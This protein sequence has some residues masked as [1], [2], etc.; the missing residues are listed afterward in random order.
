MST[1]PSIF[2]GPALWTLLAGVAIGAGSMYSTFSGHGGSLA[3]AQ[4]EVPVR[5]ISLTNGESMAALKALDNGFATLAEYA[6]PAV[7][8][9]KSES[10]GTPGLNGM[11]SMPRGGEGSGVIFRPNG[12]IVTNDH[13]V[14]GFD[15]V[16]VVLKD[17]REFPG[18]VTRAEQSDIAVVKIDADNLPTLPFADSSKVRPGEFAMAIGAPFGLENTVTIGHVSALNRQNA[19]R[20]PMTGLD[21][22]Y[23]ELIQT[24]ASINMGNSG[25]PLINVDGQVIGINSSIVSPNGNGIGLGFAISSNQ[26]RLLAETLI[27]KGK[28]TRAFLGLVPMDLKDYQK[29]QMHVDSGALVQE[30]SSD[31]PAAMAGIKA[32]DVIVRI[33]T[34]PVSDQID[35]RNAMLKYAPGTNVEV[36]IIRDGQHK[37]VKVTLKE[38]PKEV[39]QAAPQTGNGDGNG[40][41]F[42]FGP[43]GQ[44]PD[45]KDFLKQF[46]DLG[47]GNSGDGPVQTPHSGDHATL[48][49]QIHDIDSNLRKQF[50]IPSGAT[51]AVVASVVPGSMADKLGMKPGDVIQAIGDKE[52]KTAQDVK[53]AM[54]DVHVGDTKRVSYVRFGENS[55]FKEERDVTFR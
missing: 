16:T 27:E 34:I 48:G 13:V 30:V 14:G 1:K 28:V 50:A 18:K 21:R 38:Q 8:L 52:I 46:G 26:A 31:S 3:L 15:K 43:D 10:K 2:R 9:I 55:T 33:G 35:L 4:N 29:S 54:A 41:T 36:E 22:F 42:Q 37:T 32:N 19:I 24:D 23:P 25:G 20:D 49:V 44:M 51:G 12:Y 5:Q 53:D 39:A 17:G 47:G 40:R 45:V 7:V 11:T 6:S